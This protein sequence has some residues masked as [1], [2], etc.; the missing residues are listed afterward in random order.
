MGF[1]KNG[2]LRG[3]LPK[4]LKACVRGGRLDTL[5]ILEAMLGKQAGG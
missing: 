4:A 5:V 3:V 1:W 2:A